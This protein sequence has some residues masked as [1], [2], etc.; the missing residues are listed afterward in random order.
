MSK[1]Y[2]A[3]LTTYLWTLRAETLA[4]GYSEPAELAAAAWGA[5]HATNKT[6]PWTQVQVEQEVEKQLQTV[7]AGLLKEQERAAWE[8]VGRAFAWKKLRARVLNAVPGSS[9]SPTHNALT[10][11]FEEALAILGLG[12]D[13][14]D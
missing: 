13:D 3:Y 9:P 12:T 10:D 7:D 6:P 14:V 5:L 8:Q 4:T 11:A 1:I 2:T